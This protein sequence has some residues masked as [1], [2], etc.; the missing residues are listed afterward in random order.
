METRRAFR[1]LERLR[2]HNHERR[3]RPAAGSL[4]IVTV[5]MKHQDRSFR[6]FVAYR[7]A[8]AA[9]EEGSCGFFHSLGCCRR[10]KYCQKAPPPA[11][12]FCPVTHRA[13]SVARNTATSATS[14]G[15]PIRLNGDMP[16]ALSR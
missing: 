3:K 7:A 14:L 6:G 9:A 2:R 1:E 11:P 12:R 10:K 8:R 5:T 4:A 15:S 13:A 16:A